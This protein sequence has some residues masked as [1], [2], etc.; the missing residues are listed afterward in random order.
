MIQ[1]NQLIMST[2]AEYQHLYSLNHTLSNP[3]EEVGK[4]SFWSRKICKTVRKLSTEP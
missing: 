3:A 4:D 1:V 2:E